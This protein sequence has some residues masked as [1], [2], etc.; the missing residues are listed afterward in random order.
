MEDCIG[1]CT[2]KFIIVILLYSI[3]IIGATYFD[4]KKR[5][6]LK[7]AL[8]LCSKDVLILRREAA[9]AKDDYKFYLKVSEILKEHPNI[10]EEKWIKGIK[11]EKNNILITN[12]KA[13]YLSI[14][15]NIE[16]KHVS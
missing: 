10:F 14:I 11:K 8:A 7:D 13:C 4:I 2:T 6:V 9:A 12:A 5:K 3:Y 16:S 15:M 1:E